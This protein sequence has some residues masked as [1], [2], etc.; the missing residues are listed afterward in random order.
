MKD[1][2]HL[3]AAVFVTFL[4]LVRLGSSDAIAHTGAHPQARV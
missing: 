3:E 1:V 4:L 2:N